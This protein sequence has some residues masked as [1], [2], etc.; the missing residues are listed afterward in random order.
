MKSSIDHFVPYRNSQGSFAAAK[1]GRSDHRPRPSP[2][3]S[4]CNECAM[5][6]ASASGTVGK[7]LD[8]RAVLAVQPR[9]PSPQQVQALLRLSTL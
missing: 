9:R 8:A 3:R 6:S 2:R 1:R 5:R 7:L 4:E